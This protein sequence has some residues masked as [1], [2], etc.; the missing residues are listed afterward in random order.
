MGDTGEL[1]E[2]LTTLDLCSVRAYVIELDGDLAL[3]I[4]DGDVAVR[5]EAGAGDGSGW[6]AQSSLGADRIATAAT[7]FSAEQRERAGIPRQHNLPPEA[8]MLYGGWPPNVIPM[9]NEPSP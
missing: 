6:A 1:P 3:V 8:K 2:V 9:Q 4:S 5:L 7:T